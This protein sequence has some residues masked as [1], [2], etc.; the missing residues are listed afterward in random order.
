MKSHYPSM[1]NTAHYASLIKQINNKITTIIL[2]DVLPHFSLYF[3]LWSATIL[4]GALNNA[5]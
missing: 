2:V 1:T 5:A 3:V 4:E